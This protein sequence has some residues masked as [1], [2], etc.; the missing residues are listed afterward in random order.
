MMS[1]S[2]WAVR[3]KTVSVVFF[4][5]IITFYDELFDVGG[6]LEDE[7]CRFSRAL[8]RFMMSCL[9]RAVLLGAVPMGTPSFLEPHPNG[10][11][12]I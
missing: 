5:R 3:L 6:S 2:T 7:F 8:S 10:T 1:C 11:P 9:M 4:A 12:S